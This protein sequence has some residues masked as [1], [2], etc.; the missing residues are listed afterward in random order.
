ML[1]NVVA[2]GQDVAKVSGI[3]GTINRS[4]DGAQILTYALI[5]ITDAAQREVAGVLID[6]IVF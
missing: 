5:M 3:V 6:S 2:V 4:L 1:Y